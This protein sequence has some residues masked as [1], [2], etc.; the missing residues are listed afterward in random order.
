MS[1]IL[2][3]RQCSKFINRS[4][5]ICFNKSLCLAHE[6][7]GKETTDKASRE[8]S[9]GHELLKEGIICGRSLE[10]SSLLLGLAESATVFAS[11]TI[12]LHDQ[13]CRKAVGI[14]SCRI[15]LHTRC[16]DAQRNGVIQLHSNKLCLGKVKEKL[17]LNLVS[18]EIFVGDCYALHYFVSFRLQARQPPCPHGFNGFLNQLQ[19]KPVGLRCGVETY[20][21][22]RLSIQI[23]RCEHRLDDY[24]MSPSQLIAERYLIHINVGVEIVKRNWA[25]VQ[26]ILRNIVTRLANLFGGRPEETSG[27]SV[28]END[29]VIHENGH[30]TFA[31]GSFACSLTV[32]L[33]CWGSNKV[34]LLC[35]L[36]ELRKIYLGK[37]ICSGQS[38][39]LVHPHAV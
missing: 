14:R 4:V 36:S 27:Q 8:I 17:F 33:L 3:S 20:G 24:S 26:S 35:S 30:L 29:L 28:L 6:I 16:H 32:L 1:A 11:H 18:I 39:V 38:L 13:I 31:G 7:L 15:F 9:V 23:L 10:I 2:L 22:N 37:T 34:C 12:R 5:R 25:I 21:Q 19:T